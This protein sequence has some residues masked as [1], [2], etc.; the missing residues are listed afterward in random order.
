MTTGDRNVKT[1]RNETYYLLSFSV[2]LS[3]GRVQ[4]KVI[5]EGETLL[6]TQALVL[7]IISTVKTG[8][9][10]TMGSLSV[11]TMDRLT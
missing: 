2:I 11:E 10:Q 8:E 5:R 4:T 6:Y 3:C 7:V 9:T 1:N